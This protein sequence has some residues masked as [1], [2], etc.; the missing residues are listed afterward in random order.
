MTVLDEIIAHKRAEV[1]A[2]RAGTS[3]DAMRARA[4]AAGRPRDFAAAI[5]G[6]PIKIIAEVKRA[7]PSAGAI[8]AAADPGATARMY[9]SAGAAAVS[10]LTDHKYF[11]GSLDDLVAVR[12]AVDL[13]ILRKDFTVDAF[14]VYEARAAGADAVLLIAG[15]MPAADLA[16]LARLAADLGLTALV[17]VHSDRDLDDA[18]AIG[19]R[20]IGINNRNLHTLQTD[21][22]TTH[23]LRP[24]I[25]AGITVIS[26]S[27]IASPADVAN[28]AGA[29]IDAVLVGTSLMASADPGA[30]L[31]A[32]L[33]VAAEAGGG[34]P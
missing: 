20:V 3:L 19:A 34:R 32:L 17:E 31:R 9:A 11:S 5:A 2:H 10:V 16:A 1:A 6:P 21:L 33:V 25:P 27:G 28:V 8:R 13:P 22:E 14:Q 18:L 29:G 7:S 15:T 24:R 12:R 30:H 23:R 26:E 4:E